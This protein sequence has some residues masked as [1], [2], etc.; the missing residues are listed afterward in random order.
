MRVSSKT[1]GVGGSSST[2]SVKSTGSP[3]AA[4]P[5]AAAGGAIAAGD[6]LSVSSAAQFV[7][8]AKVQIAAIPDIRQDRVDALRMQ[9]DSDQYH[10]DGEAV[11]EGL[12]KEHK[13]P[14]A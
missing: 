13:P 11:A 2:G 5:V 7:A 12:L 6:A 4:A 3:S 10:P 9:M 8:V 14:E 1:G